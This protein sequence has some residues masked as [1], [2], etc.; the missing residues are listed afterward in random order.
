[1]QIAN[2]TTLIKQ[3][4]ETFLIWNVQILDKNILEKLLRKN[5]LDRET[6]R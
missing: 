2:T 5:Q 1:M 4:P 3:D 6:L